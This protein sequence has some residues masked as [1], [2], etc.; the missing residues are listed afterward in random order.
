MGENIKALK[1][2]VK[3]SNFTTFKIGGKAKY[4]LIAKNKE[5]VMVALEWAKERKEKIFVLGG[6]SN[7]LFSDKG[8]NGLVIKM[9]LN[10][11]SVKGGI[12]SAGAGVKI[13]KMLDICAR[14]SLTG[15]E[16]ASGIPGITVGG[17]IQGN[18]GAFG[19][20]I[21]D[22]VREA[23]IIRKSSL[24]QT[25]HAPSLPQGG[26]TKFPR[27]AKPA[28]AGSGRMGGVIHLSKK[29]CNFEYRTSIFKKEEDYIILSADLRL[30]KGARKTIEARIK[31]FALLRSK[32][33]PLGYPNAGSVFKNA[34][35]PQPFGK[36]QRG[37]PACARLRLPARAGR[38]AGRRELTR[39]PVELKK[40]GVVPAG[41]L[42]EQ[43][44]LKGKKIGGAMVSMKHANI[45]VNYKNAKAKDVLGLMVIIE[46]EVKKKFGIELER[47][48][49]VVEY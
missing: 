32:N 45:I 41:W 12:I 35:L 22:A 13:S 37:E 9:E 43:C 4:F 24:S 6:G 20:C 8:F 40:A 26:K 27:L 16:W 25:G 46:K 42:I 5:D 18:A 19:G 17:A 39:I 36:A 3:L 11:V 44:G 31:K 21:G 34:N 33:Q 1:K 47:E 2:G 10:N 29:E 38:R 49:E 30:K 15:L 23:D 28:C 14:N 7:A 48:I